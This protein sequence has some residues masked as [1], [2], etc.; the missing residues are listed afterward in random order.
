MLASSDIYVLVGLSCVDS[1]SWTYRSLAEYLRV[2]VSLVQRSLRRAAESGLY[3]PASRTVH[4]PNLGEFLVHA[5]RFVAPARLGAVVP[6]VPAAWAAPP[7][8]SLIV[9]SGDELPPVWPSANGRVR[10]QALEPLH[11]AAPAAASLH[12]E[13]A[14]LLA[15]VD[16]LRA[17]DL[18][19]RTVAGRVVADML[20]ANKERAL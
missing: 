16:S 15:V 7:L 19:V 4:R 8:S 2:P 20:R 14:E 11:A 18:R 5:G 1:E 3:L 6:G 10:G 13:L 17:G 9:E 12:A